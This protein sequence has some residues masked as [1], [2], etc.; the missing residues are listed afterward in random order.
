VIVKADVVGLD[1]LP[2]AKRRDRNKR[3]EELLEERCFL[4]DIDEIHMWTGYLYI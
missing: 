2:V 4:S 3:K 1:G